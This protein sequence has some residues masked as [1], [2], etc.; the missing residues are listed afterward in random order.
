MAAFH[1][2]KVSPRCDQFSP[3]PCSRPG[4]RHRYIGSWMLEMEEEPGEVPG[5]VLKLERFLE[6]LESRVQGREGP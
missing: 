1:P 3:N 6:N 4:A 2:Q 5:K